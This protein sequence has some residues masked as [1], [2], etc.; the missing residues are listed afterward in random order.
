MVAY[1]LIQELAKDNRLN[2]FI[3]KGLISL[4]ILDYKNI[5]EYYNQQ[6]EDLKN[7][8]IRKYKMQAL[9]NTCIQFECEK[10]KIYYAIKK[11]EN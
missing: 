8:G 6:K 1:Q 3:R 5:Y 2:L 9:E 4:S 10:D 7:K 11:M